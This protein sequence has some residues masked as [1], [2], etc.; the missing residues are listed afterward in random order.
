VKYKKPKIKRTDAQ[1]QP[2]NT[3]DGYILNDY[4]NRRKRR[5]QARRMGVIKNW[6]RFNKNLTGGENK[7]TYG[8][9]E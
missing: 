8:K 7:Q 1:I 4:P 6:A 9:T 2:V 5:L 3:V